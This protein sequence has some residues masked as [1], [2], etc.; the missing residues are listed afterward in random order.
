[1]MQPIFAFWILILLILAGVAVVMPLVRVLARA[2]ER[3]LEAG[4]GAQGGGAGADI[5]P[6][7]RRIEERM[8]ALEAQQEHMREH[9]EF[10]DALLEKREPPRQL[11]EADSGPG[12]EAHPEQGPEDDE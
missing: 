7:L 3:R 6:I 9:Q 2:A 10:L 12:P 1:M 8:D 4:G 5:V 11:P